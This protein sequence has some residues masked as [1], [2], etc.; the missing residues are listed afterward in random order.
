MEAHS[1]NPSILEVV[2]GALDAQGQSHLHTKLEDSLGYLRP[3]LKAT[4][5]YF[6]VLESDMWG[7]GRGSVG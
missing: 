1:L 6:S 2:A 3:C 5:N 4:T 7:W